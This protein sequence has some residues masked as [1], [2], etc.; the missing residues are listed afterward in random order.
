MTL[1][2]LLKKPYWNPKDLALA[3]GICENTARSRLA[4]IRKELSDKGF[5][6]IDN[7]QAPTRV[8]V[9]RLNIDIA[10]LEAQGSLDDELGKG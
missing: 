10:W 5:I 6:N 9:E 3:T 4:T 8:V 7:S 1:R 2:E